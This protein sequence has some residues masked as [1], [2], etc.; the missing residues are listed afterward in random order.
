MLQQLL[1]QSKQL[2]QRRTHVQNLAQ[3]GT[4]SFSSRSDCSKLQGNDTLAAKGQAAQF[5][6]GFIVFPCHAAG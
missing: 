2:Q 4:S 6:V 5:Q 3:A 1:G